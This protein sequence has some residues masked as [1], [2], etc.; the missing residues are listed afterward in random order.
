ML[1]KQELTELI[2]KVVPEA[3]FPEGTQ[4]L[5]AIVPADKIL[6][7]AEELKT[8]KETAYDYLISLTAVDFVKNM[9]VVYHLDST[10]YRQLLVLKVVLTDRETPSV[11]SVSSVW[12][13]AEFHER[14]V[15]DLFGIR[16]NNHP[17][18]KRLFL[19]DDYGYPL[20]KDFRDEINIIER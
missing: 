19:E 14:E 12:V 9:T 10:K 4:L 3:T 7:L 16:F 8:N 6:A 1:N 15:F 20:R 5:E 2:L 13:T 18:M 11:D 17:N